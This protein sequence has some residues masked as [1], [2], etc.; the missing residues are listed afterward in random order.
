MTARLRRRAA[1]PP[2]H[3]RGGRRL[4]QGPYRQ[5]EPANA[6]RTGGASARGPSGASATGQ[7]GSRHNA[8]GIAHDWPK[9]TCGHRP[10]EIDSRAGSCI[11][12]PSALRSCWRRRTTYP[13]SP[14]RRDRLRGSGPNFL[15]WILPAHQAALPKGC[16]CVEAIHTP[17][18]G[19]WRLAGTRA[20]SL[21]VDGGHDG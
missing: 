7:S 6:S 21:G 17:L 19:G 2:G 8:T 14:F 12:I 20:P 11:C 1:S 13:K 5:E 4:G 10:A 3:G 16:P 18:K 15:G 9:E